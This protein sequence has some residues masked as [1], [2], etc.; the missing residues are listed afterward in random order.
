LLRNHGIK[1]EEE[2]VLPGINAK[3]NEFQAVMGL[4]NLEEIDAKIQLRK[5]SMS[6]T[7]KN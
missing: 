1:S 6:I 5:K 2:I 4:C 7:R 3:M